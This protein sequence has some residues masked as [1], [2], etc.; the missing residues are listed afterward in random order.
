MVAD[1]SQRAH[2]RHGIPP[3]EAADP[4]CVESAEESHDHGG[5]PAC[6]EV[7][8]FP[9][10]AIVRL[11]ERKDDLAILGPI[12]ESLVQ[13]SLVLDGGLSCA[14]SDEAIETPLIEVDNWRSITD[15]SRSWRPAR[16]FP[17]W[18]VLRQHF[19]SI[20][21]RSTTGSRF[22]RLFG[23]QRGVTVARRSQLGRPA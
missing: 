11:S 18:Y 3:G 22:W 23:F 7:G 6:V 20:S 14:V 21:F 8:P 19:R 17:D 15:W 2:S 9:V 16:I 10:L 1:A 4:D 12:S 13:T 5:I